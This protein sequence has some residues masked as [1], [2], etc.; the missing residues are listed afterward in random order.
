MSVTMAK[1]TQMLICPTVVVQPDTPRWGR[2]WGYAEAIWFIV[3]ST[4]AYLP[5]AIRS[6][7]RHA[8]EAKDCAFIEIGVN[9][10]RWLRW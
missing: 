5:T 9:G 2:V 8:C 3:F 7:W 10:K 6:H 4:L 1:H